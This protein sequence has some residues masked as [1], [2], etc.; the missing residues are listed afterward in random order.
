MAGALLSIGD[1]L[2]GAFS[3]LLLCATLSMMFDCA[4]QA[5]HHL[6]CGLA[7]STGRRARSD[8]IG[9]VVIDPN[10]S[11]TRRLFR[12]IRGLRHVLFSPGR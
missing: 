4:A 7:A 1:L 6:G 10:R 11:R 2:R 9:H 5:I 3:G 8:K 12:L